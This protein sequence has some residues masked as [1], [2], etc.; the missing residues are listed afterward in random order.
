MTN[1][2]K[3]SSLDAKYIAAHIENIQTDEITITHDKLEVI[4]LKHIDKMKYSKTWITPLS[5]FGTIVIALVTSDF[6]NVWV[7]NKELIRGVFVVGAFM[8]LIW[9]VISARLCYVDRKDVSIE[10]LID[11]IKNKKVL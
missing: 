10:S 3:T 6:K 1:N 4:L 8:S 11:K 7:F 9:F 2:K 5:L